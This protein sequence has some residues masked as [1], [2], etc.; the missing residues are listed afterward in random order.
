M[1]R[2]SCLVHTACIAHEDMGNMK[3]NKTI[4]DY[5]RPASEI[6]IV[7]ADHTRESVAFKLFAACSVVGNV[8]V[9]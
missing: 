1:A 8:H 6:F 3:R 7:Y 2:V 9:V 4:Y 5:L